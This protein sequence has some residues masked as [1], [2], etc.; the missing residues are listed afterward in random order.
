MIANQWVQETERRQNARSRPDR[1]LDGLKYE[2]DVD[3]CFSLCTG[4]HIDLRG[5]LRWESH[6]GEWRWRLSAEVEVVPAV[7]ARGK[8]RSL[9]VSH[10]R[11]ASD[12]VIAHFQLKGKQFLLN[13]AAEDYRPWASCERA[14]PSSEACAVFLDGG[15]RGKL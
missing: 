14:E 10:G 1:D 4:E 11:Q 6:D 15:N 2:K 13:Q 9:E 5:E 12:H 8:L 3:W 7:A